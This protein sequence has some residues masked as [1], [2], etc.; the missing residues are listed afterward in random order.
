MDTINLV[1]YVQKGNSIRCIGQLK[2]GNYVLGSMDRESTN[3][4][5]FTAAPFQKGSLRKIYRTAL[6]QVR[7]DFRWFWAEALELHITDEDQ[8]LDRVNL[9]ETHSFSPTQLHLKGLG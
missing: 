3:I 9:I 8:V 7:K 1:A 2:S 6:H 4:H 5:W